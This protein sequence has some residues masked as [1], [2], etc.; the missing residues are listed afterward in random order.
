MMQLVMKYE[1]IV[2]CATILK[3][4]GC[5]GFI[6]GMFTKMHKPYMMQPIIIIGFNGCNIYL[7]NN[8][9]VVDYQVLFRNM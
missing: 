9:V 8:S 4:Q 6:D 7:M 1:W 2:L 3:F 5:I